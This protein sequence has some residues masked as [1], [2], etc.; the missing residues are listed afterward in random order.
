[1]AAFNWAILS[2]NSCKRDISSDVSNKF[3]KITGRKTSLCTLPEIF[4]SY[5]VY[6][7][8][9]FSSWLK[10]I[11]IYHPRFRLHFC[12][13]IHPAS[14]AQELLFMCNFWDPNIMG[15]RFQ[16]P[17]KKHGIGE[18]LAH[19]YWVC[20]NTSPPNLS[21]DE[22]ICERRPWLKAFWDQ[23]FFMMTR[24]LFT[25]AV[26]FCMQHMESKTRNRQDEV[27]AMLLIKVRIYLLCLLRI[28]IVFFQKAG[29]AKL[30][31]F[32]KK[33]PRDLHH[34]LSIEKYYSK[35]Y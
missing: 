19:A 12:R 18:I 13:A 30:L 6:F 16:I 3:V 23:H 11:R 28:S 14:K 2:D 8:E 24:E 31:V 5:L 17:T 34:D 33:S 32:G 1:M 22:L 27:I 20:I 29:Q 4:A 35:L 15:H 25:L 21:L 9:K 26:R 10:M 7:D